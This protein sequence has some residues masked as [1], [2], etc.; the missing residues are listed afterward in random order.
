MTASEIS[1]SVLIPAY[2]EEG[3]LAATV[4]TIESQRPYFKNMEIVVINDGSTDKT[5]EIAKA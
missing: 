3:A 4:A 1:V 5:S 2:N